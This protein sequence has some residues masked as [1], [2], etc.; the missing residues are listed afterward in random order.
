M[1]HCQPNMCSGPKWLTG[2]AA[3][4]TTSLPP[5]SAPAVPPPMKLN[6]SNANARVSF[7]SGK[8]SAS[9]A[10]GMPTKM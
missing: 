6:C 7:L 9:R 10:N 2:Q 5:I 1:I 8:A 3:D 4:M